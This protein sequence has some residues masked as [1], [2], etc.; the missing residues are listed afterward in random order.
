[1]GRLLVGA[2]AR[3]QIVQRNQRPAFA[4]FDGHFAMPRLGE[5]ILDRRQQIRTQTSPFLPDSFEVSPFEQPRKKSLS[6][7]LRFLRFIALAPD[8][9]VKWPPVGSTE[10][11]QRRVS[12]CRFASRCQ[13]HA[14]M[15]GGKCDGAVLRTLTNRAHATLR[16]QPQARGDTSK[17]SRE[18]QA[19]IKV[20]TRPICGKH[21]QPT[22]PHG[23]MPRLQQCLKGSR[24][25]RYVAYDSVRGGRMSVIA[26]PFNEGVVNQ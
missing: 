24:S 20:H 19:C 16:Y 6:E 26:L 15:R 22:L 11:V 7:I 14:P 3:E 23:G 12:L 13:H 17:K 2:F 18:N 10:L 25:A 8:E 9:S 5:K 4:A 21:L 1:M